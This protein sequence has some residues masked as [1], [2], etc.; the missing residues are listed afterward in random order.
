MGA[1]VGLF[2]AIG[3]E[4]RGAIRS[5]GYDLRRSKRFRRIGVIAVATVAGGVIAT[6]ALVRG[7]PVP[8]L[9][10]MG[11]ADDSDIVKG[12][13]GGADTTGQDAESSQAESASPSGEPSASESPAGSNSQ[14]RGTG[15]GTGGHSPDLVPIGGDEP[16]GPGGE[17][18]SPTAEPTTEP[19]EE[20]TS[21]GPTE[22]PTTEAPTT[23]EPSESASPSGSPS[24]PVAEQMPRSSSV[25]VPRKSPIGG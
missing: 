24:G 3:R 13:F 1:Q 5:L 23:Q 4:T 11:D 20:P 9:P 21:T 16:T 17:E 25:P 19:A 22:E 12:W 15:S 14:E 10:G 18:S 6:G 2:G 7:E 8:G